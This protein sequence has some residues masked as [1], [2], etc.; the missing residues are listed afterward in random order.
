[1]QNT[2]W[3]VVGTSFSASARRALAYAIKVAGE[4]GARIALVHAYEDALDPSIDV[5]PWL[6]ARLDDEIERS[7][8]ARRGVHVEPVLRHKA[9]WDALHH[10][11]IDLDAELIVIG[12]SHTADPL[13]SGSLMTRMITAAERLVLVIAVRQPHATQDDRTPGIASSLCS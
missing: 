2:R 9:P 11:A 4:T 10:V 13:A 5:A 8:A 6:Y 1:M 12:T 3:I 7:G